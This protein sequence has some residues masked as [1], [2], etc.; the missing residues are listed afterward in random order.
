MQTFEYI[1][2]PGSKWEFQ[3]TVPAKALK[4][5]TIQSV[6]WDLGS[7]TDL[8]LE[9]AQIAGGVV[10]FVA[11]GGRARTYKIIAKITLSDTR[12]TEAALGIIVKKT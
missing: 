2:P 12:T 6:T 5:S 8:I 9:P 10:K 11:R 4:D 3:F 1:M 7:E